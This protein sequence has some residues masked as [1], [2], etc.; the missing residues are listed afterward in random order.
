MILVR[1][2]RHELGLGEDEG[3][4]V[5]GGAGV[6]APGVDVDH[7][8]ARLVA[9]HRVED[10]VPVLVQLVVGQLELV[11][12]DHLLHP[13]RPLGGRVWVHVDPGRRVGV[14][15]ARHHPAA[16]VECIPGET[17]LQ[18]VYCRRVSDASNEGLHKGSY[19]PISC[20][21][22]VGAKPN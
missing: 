5:L 22:T 4:E 13:L 2:D 7:V 12:G 3:L 21:L 10:D 17:S 19:N 8:E 11:E 9:V 6:L 16:R 1:G 18:S 15:L 20:L 14:G